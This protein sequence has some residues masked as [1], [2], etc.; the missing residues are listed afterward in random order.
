LEDFIGGP[1]RLQR[2]VWLA[3]AILAAL[4]MWFYFDRVLAVHQIIDAAAH[5]RPRGNLSD[6]YPR[7]LGA[8]ALLLHHVNPYSDEVTIEIQEGYYGRAIDPSKPNDPRDQQR[9]AY[10]LYVVFLLAPLI[11]LPFHEVQVLFHW[12]LVLVTAGSVL[13]WLRALRWSL[14]FMVVLTTIAL[15]LGNVPAVQGVKIQQLTLLVAGLVA[16]AITC[17]SEGYL[18][19]AGVVLALATIKPQLVWELVAM[20]LIWAVSDWRRRR[21]FVVGFGV[22][23]LMLL[24]GA[25]IV[26]PSW[27][28]WFAEGIGQYHTY[29]QNQSVIEVTLGEVLGVGNV[30]VAQ[31]LAILAVLACAVVVWR[32]SKFETGRSEFAGLL[33]LVLALTVLV[34]PMYAPY[35]QVLLLP[36]VLVLVKERQEFVAQKRWRRMA[37][38]I[39]GLILVWQ[40][41]ASVGLVALYFLVS[42]ERALQGWTWPFWGTF[43]FPLWTFGLILVHFWAKG[44]ASAGAVQA[45]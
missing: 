28:K 11:W 20:L 19:A 15:V 10:P 9:F 31:L 4:S 17:I 27:C 35:N 34:V 25:Q 23:M 44:L 14:S 2:G 43:A 42:K 30:R 21:R 12:V 6:L 33:A 40:W 16:L 24:A 32:L 39:G 7:W 5:E 18:L 38:L 22:T 41:V 29:T 26:L 13:L 8:R 3:L 37:I 36:A 45:S 1:S